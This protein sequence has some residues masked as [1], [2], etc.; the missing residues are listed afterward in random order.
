MRVGLYSVTAPAS[1]NTIHSAIHAPCAIAA[2]NPY[3]TRAGITG[4][5]RLEIRSCLVEHGVRD[6]VQGVEGEA[7]ATGV[8]PII[9]R[10]RARVE[11][12]E[13]ARRRC[14]GER[15][16]MDDMSTRR[17]ERARDGG[18]EGAEDGTVGRG[19]ALILEKCLCAMS[20]CVSR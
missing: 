17:G 12:R 6:D 3:A 19:G 13:R 15:E 18:E 8:G 20:V 16:M 11:G 9:G 4:C 2:G 7:E 10:R 1:Q 14:G 5:Y